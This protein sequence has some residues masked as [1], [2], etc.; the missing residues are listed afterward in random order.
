[1]RNSENANV[2]SWIQTDTYSY[3]FFFNNNNNNTR[4]W[5]RLGERPHQKFILLN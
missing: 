5:L 4:V 2:R 1:M 3:V